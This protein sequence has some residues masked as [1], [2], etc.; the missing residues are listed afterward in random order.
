LNNGRMP[1][2]MIWDYSC[3]DEFPGVRNFALQRKL[4]LMEAHDSILAACVK[5]N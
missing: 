3:Q 4:A 5:Q 2:S 1:R